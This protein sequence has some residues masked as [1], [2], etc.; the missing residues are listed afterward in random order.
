MVADDED[1]NSH[2]IDAEGLS[3]VIEDSVPAFNIDKIYLD[4]FR[5]VTSSSGESYP[6]VNKA[7]NERINSGTLIFNYVGH[8]S[9]SGL[10]HERI[11]KPDDI[12]SWSNFN[13]L[14]LF[15][16]ATCEFSRFDDMDLNV[17][18]REMTQKTSAGE[19]V[20]FNK[21]GGGIA[22]MSTTRVVY[23]APNYFLNKNIFDIAFEPDES[24]KALRLGDI[25]RIA[26]NRSGSG[27]NKRNF[28]LLGDPAL[29]LAYPWHGKV[30][31]DSVSIDTLKALS[32][33]TVS[34]QIE[35]FSG[36][37]ASDFDGEVSPIVY[38]KENMIRTLANDGGSPMEFNLRNNILYSGK[39]IAENGMFTYT[40]IVPRDIDYSF[41]TGK[42][43]YYASNEKGDMNGSMNDLIVGGF[44]TTSLTDTTGPEITLY[45]ND[46]LFRNGG[47]SDDSPVMLAIIEDEG[48]INT[49][50]SGI[51]HDLTAYLDN[52]SNNTFVLNNY[53]ENDV[54][55]YMRG[56]I[57]YQ[58]SDL[59]EGSHSLTVKA[60]DNY[61]NSSEKSLLFLVKT[62]EDFILNNLMNYPNPF[63]TDTRITSEHN[64]PNA[65]LE[66]T[67]NIF[68]LSGQLIKIIKTS[69][70]S[71]GYM[72]PSVQW[73]GYDDGGKKV[74]RGVYPYSVTVTT[75]GN[76][77][78]RASGR[79][80]IL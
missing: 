80:I 3:S 18:T 2:M 38:D 59:E 40:F 6:E 34:G 20:L 28:S 67:V 16:T 56:Q 19:M 70:L 45:L 5:Q 25:V 61:N 9:E 65:L 74:G 15:I 44:T 47:L 37:I 79:M 36:S 13:R 69:A 72:L 22:L 12:N 4:A 58:F 78:A 60:W 75:G 35:D 68:N 21:N 39:A 54:N 23:S 55:N 57:E 51:G 7:I 50:G 14:P 53:F 77:T 31:T 64:R 1:G 24:G 33:V 30:V 63:F 71:T 42:I 17:A 76:E 27:P 66:I 41:G 26:K 11:L 73:N 46:T 52:N 32:V 10:A 48:G 49:T 29:R 43:S 62:G 8:G